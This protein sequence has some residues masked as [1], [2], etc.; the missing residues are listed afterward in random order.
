MTE[1]ELSATRRSLHAVAEL[2]LAGPQYRASGRIR[3]RVTPLGFATITDPDLRVEGPLL[4]AADGAPVAVQ[5]RTPAALGEQVGVI[6]GRPEGVYPDESGFALDEPLT[7]DADHLDT[8]L[9]ALATGDDALRAFAPADPP[10]LWPEHFDVAIRVGDINYG[11]SAGDTYLDEPYAYIGVADVPSGDF[12]NA[13]F[14][15]AQPMSAFEAAPA[16]VEFF[17]E[18][19]QR[20]SE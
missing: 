6:A 14:G 12:W 20:A 8:I 1:P 9:R 7:L 3:L 11:A 19:R 10:T 4:I 5:G 15:A 2:V 18:G 17:A 16:L 13:P